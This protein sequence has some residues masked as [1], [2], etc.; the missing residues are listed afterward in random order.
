LVIV[1][2][3]L[4]I[5]PEVPIPRIIA[6]D[7]GDARIG[8]ALSDPLGILARPLKIITRQNILGDIEDI[9]GV[10][11]ANAVELIIVGLP[12]NMDGTSGGQ[13]EKVRDFVKALQALTPL[14]IEFKDERLTTVEAKNILQSSRKNT[15]N[16]RYDAH[17]AALILQSYLDDH[18]PPTELPDDSPGGE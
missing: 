2:C 16:L 10:I 1:S 18:L 17:A 12:V 14:P 9:L 7:V 15:R 11:R 6:L 13:V 3:I 5:E 4:V 8:L